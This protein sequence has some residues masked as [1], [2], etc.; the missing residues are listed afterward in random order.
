MH[1]VRTMPA[2]TLLRLSGL[3]L[4]VALALVIV[5]GLLHPQSERLVDTVG[6]T[7][8][9]SHALFALAF[10]LVLLGLPGLYAA[11]A[12]RAGVLGLLGFVL[13]MLF[14]AYHV[15]MLLYEAGPVAAMS[16]DP[17]AD[18]LFAPGGVVQQ[19]TL[20]AWLG[21]LG[22]VAPVVFGV[23]MLRA[24]VRPTW[25]GWAVITFVPAFLV[26]AS[27]ASA[28]PTE[29]RET[30]FDLWFTPISLALAYGLLLLGLATP[31]YELWRSQRLSFGP[32]A[33]I[34]VE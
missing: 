11:Q 24:R 34:G 7:T 14:S 27:I 15:Y 12:D 25:V 29:A 17:A 8:S 22:I 10:A 2:S 16:N 28:L 3:A 6:S 26:S 19:G 9:L 4:M 13:M 31:G 18:R 33:S 20:R 5:G 21:P 23:A 30:V 1:N 32:A